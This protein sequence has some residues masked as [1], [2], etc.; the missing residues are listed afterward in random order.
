LLALTRCFSLRC[1]AS[2]FRQ[3]QER[4][5]VL[6][7]PAGA[8]SVPLPLTAGLPYHSIS[9]RC[10]PPPEYAAAAAADA[11]PLWSRPVT[12]KEGA[13]AQLH[14]L[15]PVIQPDEAEEQS[16]GEGGDAAADAAHLTPSAS[17]AAAAAA[18]GA[19]GGG[20]AAVAILRLSVHRRG[21]GAMH[22]VLESMHGEPPY[23]VEN[24]TAVP[25]QYRQVHTARRKPRTLPACLPWLAALCAI[26]AWLRPL[27]SGGGAHCPLPGRP[28]AGLRRP[29]PCS[30]I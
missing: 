24:R 16:H 25:M 2:S 18:R 15:V 27:A 7:L 13:E 20:L 1:A 11:L 8:A 10:V 30:S 4:G 17:A 6:D 22:V 9:F 19:A 29:P 23:L 3:Q 5:G 26:A 28:A 12:I 21:P 14:V